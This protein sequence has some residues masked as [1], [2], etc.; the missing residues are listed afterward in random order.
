MQDL[1]ALLSAI[2]TLSLINDVL[3]HELLDFILG[4]LNPST[5]IAAKLIE[6]LSKPNMVDGLYSILIVNTL[7]SETKEIVVKIMKHVIQSKYVSQPTKAQLRLETNNIGFGGIISGMPINELSSSIVH[8]I[9][10]LV[11]SSSMF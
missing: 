9:L 4:L 6:L 7:S 3:T 10:D 11:I 2:S 1:N 5:A 8:E